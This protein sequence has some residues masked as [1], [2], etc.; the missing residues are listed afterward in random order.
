MPEITRPGDVPRQSIAPDTT[1]PT[2]PTITAP[3]A[4]TVTSPVSASSYRREQAMRKSFAE[5]KERFGRSRYLSKARK[6]EIQ[7][8][9]APATPVSDAYIITMRPKDAAPKRREMLEDLVVREEQRKREEWLRA[10]EVRAAV[11]PHQLQAEVQQAAWIESINKML[12]ERQKAIQEFEEYK[13]YSEAYAEAARRTDVTYSDYLKAFKAG[14]TRLGYDEWKQPYIQQELFKIQYPDIANYLAA[15]EEKAIRRANELGLSLTEAQQI[16]QT[17]AREGYTGATA[18]YG[19]DPQAMIADLTA[20]AEAAQ[21]SL[22]E[23]FGVEVDP[24]HVDY[25]RDISKFAAGQRQTSASIQQTARSIVDPETGLRITGSGMSL[26]T[27][28]YPAPPAAAATTEPSPL[29]AYTREHMLPWTPAHEFF[30]KGLFEA[31]TLLAGPA[32]IAS[33]PAGRIIKADI[34]GAG[35]D[36]FTAYVKGEYTGLREDPEVAIA[37]LAIG[38]AIPGIG[39]GASFLGRAA[40]SR[41][42]VPEAVKQAIPKISKTLGAGLLGAYG[43]SV[44]VRAGAPDEAGAFPS[45]TLVSERLGRITSTEIAPAFIGGYGAQ[46]GLDITIDY[47]RTRGLPE[48]DATALIPE[49]V[50]TGRTQ[51]PVEPPGRTPPEAL[52]ARFRR[53]GEPLGFHG[54][55]AEGGFHAT[56]AP[57][58]PRATITLGRRPYEGGG[59]SIAPQISPHFLRVGSSYSAFGLDLFPASSRPTVMFMRPEAGVRVIPPDVPR[60][61]MAPMAE[62]MLSPRAQRGA[63]Y[64]APKYEAGWRRAAMESEAMIPV[65]TITESVGPIGYVRWAGR[66]VPVEER[67]ALSDAGT[68]RISPADITT[69]I[70]GI[71]SSVL[72]KSSPVTSPATFAGIGGIPSSSRFE[73]SAPAVSITPS[74]STPRPARPSAPSQPSRPSQSVP[75]VPSV[76]IPDIIPSVPRSSPP[77]SPPPSSIYDIPKP[78]SS[79]YTP[80]P[81]PSSQIT[82]SPPP[83]SPITPYRPPSSQI[84]K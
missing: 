23:N 18:K 30:S 27:S 57:F 42:G 54:T 1:A 70:P 67:I 11:L 13:K 2:A 20:Q 62:F 14:E 76:S 83:S 12:Q 40:L 78:P 75:I 9:P 64:I 69:A 24:S 48:L 63:A 45:A 10:E 34:H 82:L 17:I 47:A 65:G 73:V 72:P 58:P 50:R 39:K 60:S 53:A 3:G 51:F 16:A 84:T 43:G 71:S 66:R 4:P 15:R 77:R 31:A 74:I 25:L 29:G 49:S 41:I 59:L 5:T 7:P 36:L 81:P 28:D 55:R 56:D 46:R 38:A 8:T 19:R 33:K 37:S 79:S 68:L 22:R 6:D 61:S 44:A 52:A 80:S 26:K 35:A 21:R 32:L